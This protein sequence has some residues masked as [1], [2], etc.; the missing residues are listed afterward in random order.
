MSLGLR[1]TTEAEVFRELG[2]S[3]VRV[4]CLE[5]G[6]EWMHDLTS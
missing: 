6:G 3:C 2:D 4:A 1:L 5:G